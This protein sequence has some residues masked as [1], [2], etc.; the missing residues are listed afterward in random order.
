MESILVQLHTFQRNLGHVGTWFIH[1]DASTPLLRWESSRGVGDTRA[2]AK[3]RFTRLRALKKEKGGGVAAA[4]RPGMHQ[5]VKMIFFDFQFRLLDSG[6]GGKFTTQ[7]MLPPGCC[8]HVHAHIYSS[9]ASRADPG[10]VDFF[11]SVEALEQHSAR[12]S[13]IAYSHFMSANCF[14]HLVHSTFLICPFRPLPLHTLRPSK[15]PVHCACPYPR[16]YTGSSKIVHAVC[17]ARG[18]INCPKKVELLLGVGRTPQ[19]S[20]GEDGHEQLAANFSLVDHL[21]SHGTA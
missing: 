12:E 19:L 15:S 14:S 5:K 17:V 10:R 6:G 21:V 8:H 4:R 11:C 1:G 7:M 20:P 18:G 9:T 3:Y 2:E 13:G 16:S